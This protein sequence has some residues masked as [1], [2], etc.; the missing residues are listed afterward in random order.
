MI[1]DHAA[2]PKLK[3]ILWRWKEEFVPEDMVTGTF[4]MIYKNK[5]S[6]DD[7]SKYRMICLLPTAYKMLSTLIL[8][9]L[10]I[11]CEGFIEDD[12]CGFMR[13]KGTRDQICIFSEV[14]SQIQDFCIELENVPS[15]DFRRQE[16]RARR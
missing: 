16:Q 11:E 6:T 13:G 3:S 1:C 5:G 7:M 15:I 12:Q 4:V 10:R 8:R 2:R 14:I 9:R